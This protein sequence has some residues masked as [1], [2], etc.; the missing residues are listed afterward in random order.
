MCIKLNLKKQLVLYSGKGGSR[1]DLDN[2]L[3]GVLSF[4]RNRSFRYTVGRKAH[5]FHT[6]KFKQECSKRINVLK[7][8]LRQF[9]GA[10]Q[11]PPTPCFHQLVVVTV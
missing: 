10:D 3:D 6:L 4:V 1:P 9:S 2:K 5:S 8:L 11:E 7:V